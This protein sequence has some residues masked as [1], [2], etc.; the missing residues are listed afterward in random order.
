MAKKT[1]PK[2]DFWQVLDTRAT[3]AAAFIQ[4]HP[5]WD[6][7]GGVVAVLDTGVDMG[8]LGLKTTSE[9]K[10]KVIEARD[11]SGQ[12][13][14][15]LAPATEKTIE[16][17]QYLSVE[18]GKVRGVSTLVPQP[19]D[20]KWQLGFLDE[21]Q[22]QNSAVT[23]INHNGTTNDHFAVLTMRD[24]AG[25]YVAY[26]DLDGNGDI[27]GEKAIRSYSEQQDAFTFTLR[28][29]D[30]TRSPITFSLHIED[31]GL[32][33]SFHFDDGGHGTHV[34]GIATGYRLMGR[35][36]FHG[37]A[38]GAQVLSLKIG[39]NTLA[40]GSTTSDSM[41]RAIEFAGE[42]SQTHNRPVAINI[43]YGIGSEIEGESDIDVALDEALAQFP[44][45]SASVSAG[46]AGPGL[47]TVGTPAA[48]QW[49]V[50]AAAM[51]PRASAQSLF[52]SRIGSDQVFSFSSRGGEL[53]KPDVLLPGIASS[54]IPHFD[55]GDIKAGT[56]MAAPQL[57]GLHAL[58]NSAAV[59]TK[60]RVT[61]SSLKRALIH[62]SKPLNG[63]SPLDQGAGIPQIAAAWKTLRGLAKRK[64]P[65]SV[66]GYRVSTAVPSSLSQRGSAAYWRAG[67]YLP[68]AKEGHEFSISAVFRPDQ[69]TAQRGDFQTLLRLRSD[70]SWLRVDRGT[71]RLIGDR[72]TS[73]RVFYNR[74][75]LRQPGVY[76]ARVQVTP[77]D[78]DNVAAASL[79]NTVVTPYTFDRANGYQREF[80]KRSLEPGHVHRYPILVPPGATHLSVY[81]TAPKGRWGSTILSLYDPHGHEKHLRDW[82]ALSKNGSTASAEVIGHDLKPGIWEVMTYGS[83]RNQAA[84]NYTLNVLFR[85]IESRTIRQ[86]E[87]EPGKPPHGSFQVTNR[88]DLP[89]Q[90][91]AR[92]QVIG[93]RRT[94]TLKAPTD[95]V[96][97]PFTLNAEIDRVDFALQIAPRT[98]NRF[99][100]V[101]LQVLD[102]NGVALAKGGFSNGHATLS[103]SNPGSTTQ[104]TPYSLQIAG[105]LASDNGD[106]WSVEVEET[107]VRTQHIGVIVNDGHAITLYPQIRAH[108][109]FSLS[110]TPPRPP[111][112]Y[113]NVGTVK[114]LGRQSHKPWLVVPIDL[115]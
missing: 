111:S 114:F 34:A 88:Y 30:A 75:K 64:E 5:K 78:G 44:L 57:T 41:R 17:V 47:S 106:A 77:D 60:T 81:V 48:S 15:G 63:Y 16:G 95:T 29:P 33:V 52:G 73:I 107:Y 46:N 89:F 101:A 3:G 69:N 18:Q 103:F 55:Q 51:L 56:S 21:S 80:A 25:K 37:I 98:Y 20:G 23:D 84:S 74:S 43:S 61:G 85:G 10:V 71:A 13:D 92:G 102:S 8:I 54:S 66:V 31:E 9:G 113:T 86:F 82:R 79:W 94:H 96:S 97:M 36:G 90:G 70:S 24:D 72:P 53:S 6:G 91:S 42:W 112:G 14:V 2:G 22:F 67:T 49:A 93:F 110:A 109:D 83:F 59:A 68:D 87:S 58:L 11:F 38:P 28:K 99:T 65:F 7:R 27:T 105:G 19:K 115:E 50:A 45:L 108:L 32:T 100:D 1:T 104:S 40:G 35:K 76:T 39:N 62:S 12:G 26:V 4:A